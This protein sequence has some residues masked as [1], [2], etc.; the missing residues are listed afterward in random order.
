MMANGELMHLMQHRKR[1]N[2]AL[3]VI[4][5]QIQDIDEKIDTLLKADKSEN[6]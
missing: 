5:E 4:V 3:V 1:L 2:K 6:G